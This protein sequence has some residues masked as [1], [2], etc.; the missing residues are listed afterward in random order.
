MQGVKM[1]VAVICFG[2][3]HRLMGYT[4]G[5]GGGAAR[6]GDLASRSGG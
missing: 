6:R 5:P 4:D 1:R 2:N 3:A